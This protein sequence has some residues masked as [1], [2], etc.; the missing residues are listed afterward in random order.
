MNWQPQAYAK[1]PDLI[2]QQQVYAGVV[3]D[4]RNC[5]EKPMIHSFT[6]LCQLLRALT[7]ILT[8]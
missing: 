2:Q 3:D 6:Q 8:C 5:G 1:E 4:Q 7:E